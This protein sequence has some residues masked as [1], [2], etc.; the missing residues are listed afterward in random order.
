MKLVDFLIDTYDKVARIFAHKSNTK[1][2]KLMQS[3]RIS[4]GLLIGFIALSLFFGFIWNFEPDHFEPMDNANNLAKERNENIVTGYITTATL[5]KT[6]ET[7][8][9]KSGGF[10][11]NDVMPPSLFM[12]N[13]PNWERGALAQIRDLT[14]AMR[15]DMTRS[16]S[17]SIE[18]PD[19][20]NAENKFRID[21][22]SWMLP[23]AES[24]Y[25]AATDAL[26]RYLTRLTDN[27]DQDGQFFA[28]ADNLNVW[29]GMV[30]KQLGS[31]SQRL[32][33]SVGQERLNTDLA[34]DAEALQ[35]TPSNKILEV[36]TPWLKIDDVFFR[37]RG[38][39]WALMHLLRA[40]ETDFHDIL[41]KK[42]AL[43]SLQQIIR[44]LDSAQ[45]TVWSP[46]ILN[47]SGFGLFANHS[48]VMANYI[49]RANAAVIDLRNLLDNG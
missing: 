43:V 40:A 8:L 49:S 16:Q 3:S 10:L 1:K 4:L 48:L 31:L 35:S 32:S 17:Q 22:D 18:D 37:A 26:Y 27:K 20:V 39:S 23:P 11:S 30:S 25:R 13:I 41:Q 29:L 38:S 21:T 36:K 15:N 44:E 28:R 19:I 12:D 14:L 24:E 34:G 45:S 46:I 2:N 47:G 5:I 33:A 7:L 9:D 6:A 42:N